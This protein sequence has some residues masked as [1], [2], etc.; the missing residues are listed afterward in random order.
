MGNAHKVALGQLVE[1]MRANPA[2]YYRKPG[3]VKRDRRLNDNQRMDILD[4]WHQKAL[5]NRESELAAQIFE[6]KNAL[7]HADSN[8]F[9]HVN[10]SR[11]DAG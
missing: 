11:Y 1:S 9:E 10:R 7:G 5:L 3:D 6:T 8:P 4:A 2:R